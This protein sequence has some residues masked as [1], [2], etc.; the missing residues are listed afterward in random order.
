M[1]SLDG[2]ERS[3]GFVIDYQQDF[4]GIWVSDRAA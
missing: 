3:T 2:S 4:E 1:K